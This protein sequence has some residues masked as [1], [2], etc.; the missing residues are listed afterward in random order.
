MRTKWI[1]G[2]LPVACIALGACDMLKGEA[3]APTGQV[4]ATVDGDEITVAELRAELA[5]MNISDPQAR[6]SAE[7][8][9]LQMIVNRKILAKAAEEQK[10]DKTPEFAMQEQRA[11]ESLRANALQERIVESVPAPTRDE[12]RT[13]MAAHPHMFGER[14]IFVVDQIRTPMPRDQQFIKDLEPLKTLEEVDAL[15]KSRNIAYQRG[16]DRIDALGSNPE[17]VSAIVKLPPNEVFVVPGGQ[18][19]LINRIRETRVEPF[20]GDTALKAATEMLRRQRIRE[21]VEKQF[22]GLVKQAESTV[23]YNK[24]YDPKASA[25]PAPKTAQSPPKA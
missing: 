16:T 22:S 7:Q 8:R 5:G 3:K 11:M 18:L 17:L 25:K 21:A 20:T 15:L 4:V 1:Y 13:F 12:A 19:L 23:R 2:L 9:A 24:A 14:K 10:L 6:K